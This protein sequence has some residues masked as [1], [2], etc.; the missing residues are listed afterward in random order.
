M[1]KKEEAIIPIENEK[2]KLPRP[3]TYVLK[4]GYKEDRSGI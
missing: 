2:N 1:D 3:K 4:R